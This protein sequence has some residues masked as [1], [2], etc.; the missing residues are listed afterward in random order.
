M[1]T[2]MRIGFKQLVMTI[3]RSGSMDTEWIC[4]YV[5]G[6]IELLLPE[7]LATF[8]FVLGMCLV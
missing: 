8:R 2:D 5:D 4:L 6:F 1:L 3:L 7:I